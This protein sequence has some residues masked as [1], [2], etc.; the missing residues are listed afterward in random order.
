MLAD[1]KQPESADACQAL[2][3][4]VV[5]SFKKGEEGEAALRSLEVRPPSLALGPLCADG[6]T[7]ASGLIGWQCAETVSAGGSCR[8]QAVAG[9]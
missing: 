4:C 2:C 6:N 5:A 7:G 3:R 1:E 8:Q 9:R